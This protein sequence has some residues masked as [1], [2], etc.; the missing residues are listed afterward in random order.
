VVELTP[1]LVIDVDQ[2]WFSLLEQGDVDQ[3]LPE[4]VQDGDTFYAPVLTGGARLLLPGLVTDTDQFYQTQGPSAR[5]HA[6]RVRL[7]GS[8]GV[9]PIA[10][11]TDNARSLTGTASPVTALSG[12][13]GEGIV[14]EGDASAVQVELEGNDA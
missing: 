3:L 4:M 10:A 1:S 12:R 14:L 6:H 7:R 2:Y 9:P 11:R 5:G 8:V 13:G